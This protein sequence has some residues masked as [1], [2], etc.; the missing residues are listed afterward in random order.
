[1]P[2]PSASSVRQPA[3]AGR[4][5]PADSV[6][7]RRE[8][9]SFLDIGRVNVG[10]TKWIGGVV[11]HAG[12]VCSGAI[13]GQTIA[14][15]ASGASVDVVVVFGAVHT[16][17][18]FEFGALDS[19]ATWALPGRESSLP[20]EVERQLLGKG[21]VFG[22]EPRLHERE[23]AVEVEVPLIQLAWPN[24]TILPIE[25]P[26]VSMAALIG[27]KTAQTLQA[28]GIQ[29]VYLASSDFTHYGTNYGFTPAGVGS[30][31]MQWTKDNDRRVL[32][33]IERLAVDEIVPEVAR[34]QN[35]CGA[36]AIAAMLAAC[37]EHG[38]TQART[39][40]HATSYETLAKVMPQ[41]PTNA[42]GYAS[43]VIG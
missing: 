1:M 7:C 35:A 36:G 10:D 11:P 15:L 9:Q 40:T 34:H 8:A 22:V 28:A 13:A 16:P 27:R 4:F 43:I 31:A 6:Q 33:M 25:V 39:I 30:A 26:A 18:R 29:A 37:R 20:L 38:A 21:T 2:E 14:T 32:A 23:H 12:W 24:A 5:Y 42:V 41:E 17:Y 3:V 19:H